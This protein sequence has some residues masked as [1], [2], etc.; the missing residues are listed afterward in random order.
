MDNKSGQ[1][2]AS[3]SQNEDK[4]ENKKDDNTITKH[5]QTVI[6]WKRILDLKEKLGKKKK[7]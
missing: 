2:I 5:D 3:A 7:L 6:A 4:N 1:S